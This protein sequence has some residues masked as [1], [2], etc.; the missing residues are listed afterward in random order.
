[1]AQFPSP[2]WVAS[3]S[4]KLNSDEQYAHVAHAWEADMGFLV[5]G[6]DKFPEPVRLYLDLWHG[7]CR[8]AYM[9]EDGSELKAAFIL[10]ATYSNIVQLLK[11]EVDPIQALIMRKVSVQG[12]YA[13]LMRSVPVV[14]HFVRCCREVTDSFV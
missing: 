6:R 2:E 7:K 10:K 14:L 9:L 5:D 3:L 8:Q 12:N 1:M 4:D 13:L 11:G